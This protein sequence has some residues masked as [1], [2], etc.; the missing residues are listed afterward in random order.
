LDEELRAMLLDVLNQQYAHLRVALGD[1]WSDVD[2]SLAVPND[3]VLRVPAQS[4]NAFRVDQVVGY[5]ACAANQAGLLELGDRHTFV[6]PANTLF[7]FRCKIRLV[8]TD[9]RILSVVTVT[10]GGIPGARGSG[11]AGFISLHLGGKEIPPG[12]LRW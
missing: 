11:T 5:V 9:V 1:S 8:N 10:A 4:E 3:T 12:A 7:S 2:E 6:V